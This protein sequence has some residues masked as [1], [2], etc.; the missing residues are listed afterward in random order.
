MLNE[1]VKEEELKIKNMGKNIKR[2]KK[3]TT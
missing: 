2:P 1:A 3:T